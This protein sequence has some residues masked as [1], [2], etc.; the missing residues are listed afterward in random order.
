MATTKKQ[1][2]GK[3]RAKAVKAR[4]STS[5]G[6]TNT[7]YLG[8]LVRVD[9]RAAAAAVLKAHKDSKGNSTRAAAA[10]GVTYPHLLTL[11]ARL[12][13]PRPNPK[14]PDEPATVITFGDAE[15]TLRGA[16]DAM[17][18]ASSPKAGEDDTS[19][20]ALRAALD[21]ACERGER[22][23][24]IA[25]AI[26]LDGKPLDLSL[27]SKFRRGT[28]ELSADARRKLA[29]ELAKRAA[30]DEPAAKTQGRRAAARGDG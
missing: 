15:L 20:E 12:A 9:P 29:R 1:A 5:T 25:A 2:R 8:S 22:L 19:P 6:N 4:E 13:E 24:H 30:K 14:K 11:I 26:E 17:R 3:P 21:A 16:I 28:R 7:S 10:L 27:L 18:T 23:T